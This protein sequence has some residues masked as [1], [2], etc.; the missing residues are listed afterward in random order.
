MKLAQLFVVVMWD[1]IQ[2]EDHIPLSLD[3]RLK[4]A[5]TLESN[6][7]DFFSTTSSDNSVM[8]PCPEIKEAANI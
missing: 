1:Y 4:R 7:M 2:H 8:F 5:A 3:T 6:M